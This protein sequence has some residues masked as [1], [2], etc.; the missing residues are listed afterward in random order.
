MQHEDGGGGGLVEDA[1]KNDGPEI[2]VGREGGT[3]GVA[4]VTERRR[5][6]H[7]D[8]QNYNGI[9][10]GGALPLGK[11]QHQ[12][13]ALRKSDGAYAV[14]IQE[15][16][17]YG[18]TVYDYPDKHTLVT[19]GLMRPPGTHEDEI[20][21]GSSGVAILLSPEAARAWKEGGQWVR[22]YGRDVIAIK[23]SARGGKNQRPHRLYLVSSYAPDSWKEASLRA[24]HLERLEACIED[25]AASYTLIVGTDANARLGIRSDRP[26]ASGADKNTVGPFGVPAADNKKASSD[27]AMKARALLTRHGLCS[28]ATYFEAPRVPPGC[29]SKYHTYY[30]SRLDTETQIDHFFVRFRDLRKCK[31]A[32]CPGDSSVPSDHR[33]IRL[34]LRDDV[35]SI[36]KAQRKGKPDLRLLADDKSDEFHQFNNAVVAAVAAV[37]RNNSSSAGAATAAADL[38]VDL[39]GMTGQSSVQTVQSSVTGILSSSE[40]LLSTGILPVA[41][42]LTGDASLA[43]RSEIDQAAVLRLVACVSNESSGKSGVNL[44]HL[45][46][47]MRDAMSVLPEVE[48]VGE[49]TWY[50]DSQ[51]KLEPLVEERNKA[52]KAMQRLKGR[53][54][55]EGLSKRV[56]MATAKLKKAC[57]TAINVWV[58]KL[59]DQVNAGGRY[60]LVGDNCRQAWLI[61]RSLEG[62]PSPARECKPLRPKDPLT[63]KLS[64][65]EIDAARVVRKHLE[66]AHDREPQHEEGRS[67]DIP[68]RDVMKHTAN[69]PTLKEV[70]DCV[71][72]KSNG[73]NPG[74]SKVPAEAF[75]CLFKSTEGRKIIM[76][77]ID[78]VWCSGSYPGEHDVPGDGKTK[79]GDAT[80]PLEQCACCDGTPG[81]LCEA[82]DD[83]TGGFLHKEW[84]MSRLCLIPKK[85]DLTSMKNWR[86]L[87]LLDVLSLV[88]TSIVAKRIDSWAVGNLLDSQNGFRWKRGTTDAL[89]NVTMA[90]NQRRRA[91]LTTW[92]AA[93]DLRAAFDSVSRK[94]LFK[95]MLKLGFAPHLVNILRRL[96]TDAKMRFKIGKEE[97]EVFNR[98]GVRTGDSCGP[99]LFLLCM[100]AVFLLIQWP[101]GG[102]PC[103]VA[104]LGGAPAKSSGDLGTEFQLPSS[105]YADDAILLFTSR[106]ALADGLALFATEVQRMTGMRMHYKTESGGKA[107]SKTVAMCFPAPGLAYNDMD[108]SELTFECGMELETAFVDFVLETKYLGVII[109]VDLGSE[110][111]VEHR[112]QQA[113]V[114]MNSLRRVLMNRDLQLRVRGTFMQATVLTILLYGSESWILT[115]ALHRK[116]QTFYNDSCRA[117]VGQS[118]RSACLLGLHFEGHGGILQQL[119][120]ATLDTYLRHRRYRWFGQLARMLHSRLPRLFLTSIAQLNPCPNSGEFR[121]VCVRG[122]ASAFRAAAAAADAAA[123]AFEKDVVGVD[124]GT[125][126]SDQGAEYPSR[127]DV[128]DDSVELSAGEVIDGDSSDEGDSSDVYDSVELDLEAEDAIVVVPVEHNFRVEFS[129]SR[130]SRCVETGTVI[131]SQTIRFALDIQPFATGGRVWTQFYSVAGLTRWLGR[132]EAIRLGIVRLLPGLGQLNDYQQTFVLEAVSSSVVRREADRRRALAT[133]P[134][135]VPTAVPWS[136]PRCGMKYVRNLACA[137]KHASC[138]ACK[139]KALMRPR[140]M[141]RKRVAP[142]YGLRR[143]A[144]WVTCFLA[145]VRRGTLSTD[146]VQRPYPGCKTCI[147]ASGAAGNGKQCDRC[148]LLECI[149]AAQDT[150]KWDVITY[151]EAVPGS[152]SSRRRAERRKR[153]GPPAQLWV[154][155]RP[156]EILALQ[157][158]SWIQQ[159]SEHAL[160]GVSGRV[161]EAEEALV[162]QADW[163]RQLCV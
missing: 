37:V 106:A 113:Q 147:Q 88:L 47:A 5:A 82:P 27:I 114:A 126:S 15:T 18:N 32:G 109:H 116:L 124:V 107:K 43:G 79:G 25:C 39:E 40:N 62:G 92:A 21:S 131:Q 23:L 59:A 3:G 119:H 76:A 71:N 154:D 130:E 102:K 46:Q 8:S 137:I 29:T 112:I 60:T 129:K 77:L 38:G 61:L 148:L 134:I 85:G 117:L 34:T 17:L 54:E 98:A 103:F 84:L 151:G 91:G 145:Q 118:K 31:K 52:Y 50:K 1:C 86:S 95:I 51:H 7:I 63:G 110:R 115:K 24:D 90:L 161:E 108:T 101:P 16:K 93:V 87:C 10:G 68:Q 146:I 49:K 140:G 97:R 160:E 133:L 57:L 152:W 26:L 128:D 139:L 136:C 19:A 11:L 162:V 121:H 73:K 48:K 12:M 13:A 143:R 2:V 155:P 69:R 159:L 28:A 80:H 45:H 42:D 65:T 66:E 41:P 83:D 144:T 96:H 58:V 94:A 44:E 142:V 104:G 67:G 75:K 35:Y 6:L 81:S 33:R 72:G 4:V 111:A 150:D 157:S 30:S 163:I 105:E 99:S 22:R 53:K 36:T 149:T 120:L 89:W 127:V 20:Y 138:S 132:N 141:R 56:R 14:L 153:D 55:R 9:G 64:E 100:H 123:A 74:D 122:V 78:D 70:S 125:L 135:V 156:G 158:D